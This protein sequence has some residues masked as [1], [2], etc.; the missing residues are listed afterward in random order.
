MMALESACRRITSEARG[1]W[2]WSSE[3]TSTSTPMISAM[4]STASPTEIS[5]PEPAL[6]VSP[7]TSSLAAS[8]TARKAFAVSAT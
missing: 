4:S 8:S 5:R 6:K 2:R 1:R 7:T 3:R